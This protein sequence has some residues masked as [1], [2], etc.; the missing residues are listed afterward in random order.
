MIDSAPS[1]A[2]AALEERLRS[3]LAEVER[4]SAPDDRG[5][6]DRTAR[7]AGLALWQAEV[8]RLRQLLAAMDEDPSD[9]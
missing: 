5:T 6:G 3:A 4:L 1:V 8:E 9:A 7:M 2:R